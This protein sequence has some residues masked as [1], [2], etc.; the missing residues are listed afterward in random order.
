MAT[1]LDVTRRGKVSPALK[2]KDLVAL[3]K[4]KT[5]MDAIYKDFWLS[6]LGTK[7]PRPPKVEPFLCALGETI[8]YIARSLPPPRPPL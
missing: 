1:R 3:L 2:P 8:D 4:L 6:A 7:P 5:Q